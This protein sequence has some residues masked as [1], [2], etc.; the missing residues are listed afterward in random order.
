MLHM[1]RYIP[2]AATQDSTT[3]IIGIRRPSNHVYILARL[4]DP[5]KR[6]VVGA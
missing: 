4:R 5:R 6:L 3:T 2:Q 1:L